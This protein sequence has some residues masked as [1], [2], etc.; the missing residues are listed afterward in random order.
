MTPVH[1]G[2]L[3][4]VGSII[5]EINNVVVAGFRTTRTGSGSAGIWSVS[6]GVAAGALLD[7]AGAL[8]C[9]TAGPAY[10]VIAKPLLKRMVRISFMWI[11]RCMGSVDSGRN[12]L[13]CGSSFQFNVITS[14]TVLPGFRSR[15]LFASVPRARLPTE[16]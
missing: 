6:I 7:S 9:V 5:S 12:R 2:W 15:S 3:L 10:R 14:H 8:D 1:F 16:N 11:L 13:R 4:Q